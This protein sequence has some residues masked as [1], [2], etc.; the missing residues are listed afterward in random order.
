MRFKVILASA[1][2]GIAVFIVLS[3]TEDMFGVVPKT[4]VPINIG[5]EQAINI[6]AT[7]IFDFQ[8]R[9]EYVKF[10]YW[11]DEIPTIHDGEDIS[12][13]LPHSW[14]KTI[15]TGLWLSFEQQLK[16]LL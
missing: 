4:T 11:T 8:V 3:Q 12:R 10:A 9:A 16:V 13:R 14:V 7:R 6:Q 1:I 5:T 2:I 15:G